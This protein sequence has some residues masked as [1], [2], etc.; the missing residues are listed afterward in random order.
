MID[1]TI[2][3]VGQQPQLFVDNWLIEQSDSVTR[4]WHK[5]QRL[6]D[7]PVLRADKPWEDTPYFTYSNFN[8]LQDPTDGLIKCWYEDL[9]PMEPH[10]RHP[11]RNR[12]L[13]AV[14]EDGVHFEKPLMDRVLI[15][16]QRTN[17]FAG[18]VEGAENSA[19]NPWADVGVHSGAVVIDPDPA[20]PTQRY[21]MLFTRATPEG[22]HHTDIAHSA[23]GL[24]WQSYGVQPTFGN[25]G[26]KLSDVS[27]ITYDPV[28]KL[29]L[30][31]TR[32][33]RMTSAGAPSEWPDVPSGPGGCFSSYWPNRPD[34]MNKRRVFRT[35]SSDFLNW[36]DLVAAVTPDDDV[37]N[38]DEAF[39][40][41]GQFRVGGV[42]FGTLGVLQYVNNE[43]E[44][45]LVYSRDGFNWQAT[46]R[47]NAFLAPRGGD[48]WDRHMVSIVSPPVRVGDKWHFYHGGSWAHHDYWWSGTQK[49]D[50]AEARAPGDEVRFGM[51]VAT[52]RFEGLVSLQNHGPRTG[53]IVT[54]P[55]STDGRSLWVNSQ[56]DGGTIR[57]AISDSNGRILPGRSFDDCAPITG[58]GLRNAVSWNGETVPDV[59]GTIHRYIKVWFEIDNAELFSFGFGGKAESD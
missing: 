26:G 54:R 13:Y 15:D 37:D 14:S 29:Y 4:R 25:A 16:G 30:Q 59:E 50:H 52:L 23:D 47:A 34:L 36:S 51:G 3:Q 5:P 45:R 58:D 55:L 1:A 43:M 22:K 9:G 2:F 21:R 17:I 18:Y 6:G 28:T 8:V 33:G 32:H 7:Q 57:V 38:L 53:R 42:H 12:M 49:L 10:Q 56:G 35:V 41:L 31:Y 46:D 19:L 39:Y 24:T 27:T 20:D 11:W 40:G 48:H 44:V